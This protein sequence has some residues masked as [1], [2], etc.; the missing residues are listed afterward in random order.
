MTSLIEDLR[1]KHTPTKPSDVPKHFVALLSS[2]LDA[3]QVRAQVMLGGSYAKGTYL[4]GDHDIDVFVRFDKQYKDEEMPDLLGLALG[5]WEGLQRIHGS[6]DYFQIEKQGFHFEIVPVLYVD[7]AKDARNVTDVSPLHVDYVKGFIQKDARIAADIRLAKLFCKAAKVYGAES[8]LNGFSGHVIDNLIIHYGSFI[9]LLEAAANW[10]E[11]VFID[12]VDK[13]DNADFLNDAKKTGPLILLDPIQSER[14]AAAA[15]SKEK[16]N[17]FRQAAKDFLRHPDESFF[18]VVPLDKDVVER[19]HRGSNVF[20]Y[21]LLPL[22]GSKD[23]IGTKLLKAHEHFLKHVKR[24]GFSIAGSGFEF[25]LDEA[26]C[27][28]ATD[29]K[30]LS[31]EYEITGPPLKE[32]KDAAR[33]K[34]AHP[35][36]VTVRDARLYAIE[37]RPYR[38]IKALFSAVEQS[39]YFKERVAGAKVI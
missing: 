1:K 36:K 31:E 5:G 39:T 28:I 33:F 4:E 26:F 21:A 3:A 9:A 10:P 27:F 20:C 17:A 19:E 32:E 29:E 12:P 8:Y 37:P 25:S 14:N 16:F 6:R 30:K 2:L 34:E 38:T 18:V 7:A 22:K 23:V 15:L 13:H 35:G 11:R 24:A